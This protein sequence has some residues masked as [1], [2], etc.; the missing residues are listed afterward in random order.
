MQCGAACLCMVARHYGRRVTL[1]GVEEICPP[2]VE[3]VSMQVLKQAARSLGLRAEAGRLTVSRLASVPL[4]VILHWNQN[5]FVVLYKVD[6]DG[7]RFHIADPGKGRRKVDVAELERC[8]LTDGKGIAMA[9]LDDPSLKCIPL[10]DSEEDSLRAVLRIAAGELRDFRGRIA[11]LCLWLLAGAGLDLLLPFLM[12]DIVDVGIKGADL[13]IVI[14][15]L[16]GEVVIIGGRMTADLVR[17]WILLRV[18]MRLNLVMISDFFSKLLRLPMKFFDTRHIGDLRQRITDHERIQSFLTSQLPGMTFAVLTFVIFSVALAMMSV[19]VF[20]VFLCA[21]LLYCGWIMMFLERRKVLDYEVFEQQ[22][23]NQS[24]IYHLLNSIQEIKLQDCGD[25]KRGEWERIQMDLFGIQTRSLRL[26]QMQEVGGVCINELKNIVITVWAASEVIK[27]RMTL[28]DMMAIQF[29]TGQLNSPVEQFMS[30]VYGLQDIRLSADRIYEIRK[31]PDEPGYGVQDGQPVESE[32]DIPEGGDAGPEGNRAG[33]IRSGLRL[34]GV[35]F[36]YNPY[37]PAFALED[38]DF[39]ARAGKVTAI[40]GASG[41]GKTTLLKLLLGYYTPEAGEVEVEGRD[42]ESLDRRAWR[43]RCGCVMQNGVIFQ[44]SIAR[45]IAVAGEEVDEARIWEVLRLA[46]MDE[47]VRSLPLGL[48]TAIGTDGHGLSLGQQQRLLI[49]R[50]L[51]RNPEYI[52]LDEATNSL[53]AENERM[54][55]DS[56]REVFRGKTVIVIAHRLSTVRDADRIVVLS[57]GKVVEEGSHDE[58]IACR[59]HYY[60]LVRNQLELGS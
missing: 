46:R 3:G 37:D 40:V 38:V 58:L 53:D 41:S 49:A 39:E 7:T 28:G 21:S 14:L 2:S 4:P 17:R 31:R 6:R 50:A 56:L 5:H 20:L 30:L 16:L 8:W 44:D 27:G 33:E 1:E 60:N 32:K 51:Y 54:I 11:K 15:I 36:R 29:I 52:F 43:K 45:N 9:F 24:A 57:K 19:K 25:R 55:T 18:S 35:S 48:S 10:P 26:R 22:A 42:M 23:R 13:N 34:N 12:R 47:F 59:G